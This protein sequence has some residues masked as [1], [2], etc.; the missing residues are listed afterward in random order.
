LIGS[1]ADCDIILSDTLLQPEH[2]KIR[3]TGEGIEVGLTGGGAHLDGEPVEKSPFLIRAG[4]VLSIGSTHI[5]F[6]EAGEVWGA[7]SIPD[8]KV[9]GGVA[10]EPEVSAAPGSPSTPAQAIS[11]A[12]GISGSPVART[13]LISSGV[14]VLVVLLGFFSTM[15]TALGAGKV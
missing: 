6:G 2:C 11:T 8:L 3:V 13:V 14:I 7:V 9:L 4:Q 12:A 10:P 1:G 15:L 5:A